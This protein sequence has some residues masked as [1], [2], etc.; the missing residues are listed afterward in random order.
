MLRCRK[1]TTV[2]NPL[3]KPI[4]TED[5][6]AWEWLGLGPMVFGVDVLGTLWY[7]PTMECADSKPRIRLGSC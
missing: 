1:A 5:P 3:G 2:R 4:L 6:M 7:G